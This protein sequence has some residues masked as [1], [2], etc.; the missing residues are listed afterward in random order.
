MLSAVRFYSFFLSVL[1]ECG[2]IVHHL[3]AACLE[4]QLHIKYTER[5]TYKMT[6]DGVKKISHSFCPRCLANM[7]SRRCDNQV[8]LVWSIQ[9]NEQL[10]E[11]K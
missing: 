1:K 11:I 9:Q 3:I 2:T 5:E 4:E 6:A 10:N 7:H 8:S